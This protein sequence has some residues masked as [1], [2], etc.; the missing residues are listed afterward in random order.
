[1]EC[2]WMCL[3]LHRQTIS[4]TETQNLSSKMKFTFVG[5]GEAG[6]SVEITD[7]CKRSNPSL[8]SFPHLRWWLKTEFVF[9][10]SRDLFV[11]HIVKVSGNE[12]TVKSYFEMEFLYSQFFGCLKLIAL[13]LILVPRGAILI[14][15]SKLYLKWGWSIILLHVSGCLSV[16]TIECTVFLKVT[17]WF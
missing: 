2:S 1:M 3:I 16:N 10:I 9:S 17:V 14:S 15:P 8:A 11:S 6:K 5:T 13:Y 7:P 4:R 12:H